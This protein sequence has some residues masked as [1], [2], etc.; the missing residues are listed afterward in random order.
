LCGCPTASES[1]TS[2]ADVE[3]LRSLSRVSDFMALPG[4][5][6]HT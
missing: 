4:F 1:A 3:C 6:S 5:E 2:I